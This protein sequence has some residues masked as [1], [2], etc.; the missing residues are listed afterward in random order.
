MASRLN[1]YLSF[2]NNAREA[3]E[4]YREALGGDLTINTFGD[5]GNDDPAVASLVMHARL[6]TPSGFTLMGS[7]TPPDTAVT[8]DLERSSQRRDLAV[9]LA[10]LPERERRVVVLRYYL[11]VSEAQVATELGVS[12][13]TVKST[14]SRALAK[15]RT[16][17]PDHGLAV[18]EG[19]CR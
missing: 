19:I 13:G 12:V 3:M 6:G 7:D 9:M 1:P 8:P 16:A 18:T 4:F 11:D 5:L 10:R 14:A 17:A 15:L 2:R